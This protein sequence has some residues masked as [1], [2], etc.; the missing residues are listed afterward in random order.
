[1]PKLIASATILL[2]LGT[3]AVAATP[4]NL[5][6]ATQPAVSQQPVKPQPLRVAPYTKSNLKDCVPT[7]APVQHGTVL[8]S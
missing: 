8:C 6:A 7:T 1:M 4:K 2:C 3:A 5:P